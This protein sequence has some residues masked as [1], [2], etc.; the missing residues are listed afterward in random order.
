MRRTRSQKQGVQNPHFLWSEICISVASIFLQSFFKRCH[1]SRTNSHIAPTLHPNKKMTGGGG[2]DTFC[3][4]FSQRRGACKFDVTICLKI[5]EPLFQK[6]LPKPRACNAK[7]RREER[8]R[9]R[10][11][12]WWGEDMRFLG[13]HGLQ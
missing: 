8:D 9:E 2:D 3:G 12:I 4:N 1:F 7:R 13:H 10:H 11:Y 6:E 5:G